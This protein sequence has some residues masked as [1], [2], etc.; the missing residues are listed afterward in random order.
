M[1][2]LLK[3]ITCNAKTFIIK[4]V[5][6]KSLVKAILN[7]F[8]NMMLLTVNAQLEANKA[9]GTSYKARVKAMVDYTTYVWFNIYSLFS[10]IAFAAILGEST[11]LWLLAISAVLS[12]VMIVVPAITINNNVRESA[13]EIKDRV[14]SFKHVLA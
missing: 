1:K 8:A 12:L 3:T 13:Q 9:I 4:N 11:V 5:L 7:V 10:V 14:V 6:I 2:T